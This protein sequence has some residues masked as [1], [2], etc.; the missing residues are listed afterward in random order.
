MEAAAQILIVLILARAF[1]E[2][3]ER[4]RQPASVGEIVAG[5]VLAGIL[6]WFGDGLPSAANL[7]ASESLNNVADLGMFCLVLLAGVDMEPKEIAD[8]SGSSLLVA[9]GGT[10]V[11]L[12]AGF[13]LGWLF[14][15]ESDLKLAQALL[16]GVAMSITAIPAVVK[17]FA[18]VGALHSRVG[19]TVVSAAIFDDVFGLF[20]LAL[21]LAVIQ[22]GH[23]PDITAFAILLAKVVAFFAITIALGVHVYP[24]VSR[25]MKAL[26][27]AAFEFS[28]LA[29]V[30][31]AYGLL[32]DAL[33]I[34]WILGAFMA[35]LYFEKSRVG[36]KAY[37]E[38]RLVLGAIT[39]GFLGPIF[40]LSIGLRVE[41]GA[42][43]AVPLFLILLIAVAFFGKLVGAGLPALWV[44][45]DRREATAVGIGMSA[46]G[47]V[48]LAVL[49]IAYHA[50]LFPTAAAD[51]S[52]AA[53][54][55]SALILMGVVTTLAAPML[56]RR[57]LGKDP[58]RQ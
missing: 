32:A 53:Y 24:R 10:A 27:A 54:L 15:P 6:L 55:F 56:L 29:A 21:I 23:V 36:G 22:T 43:T 34:H 47:A 19:R 13:G 18:E 28:A 16:V 45:L 20:L 49:N 39:M 30:A 57:T 51:G 25:G 2:A 46:R 50:G 40:F 48:E 44:G 4:L 58:N 41:L 35:G 31:L 11:P 12:I 7:A 26:Q 17:M 37:N 14:L 5:I 1:G 8:R 42:I 33:G 38:I 52:V 9:A 3:A